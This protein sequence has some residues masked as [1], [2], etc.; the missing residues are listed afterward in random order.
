MITAFVVMNTERER[1]AAIPEELLKING[2][3]E[4]YSV[5]GNV[6]LVAVIRVKDAEEV[7]KVV[8]EHFGK[9]PGITKTRTLIAFRCHSHYDLEHIFQ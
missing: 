8:T 2:V 7:A 9:V 3:T 6:D 1:I 4:V 5:A